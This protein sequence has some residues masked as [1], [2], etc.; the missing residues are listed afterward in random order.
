MVQPFLVCLFLF[1]RFVMISITLWCDIIVFVT[2]ISYI[3]DGLFVK[4][5]SNILCSVVGLFIICSIKRLSAM[6]R[7]SLVLFCCSLVVTVSVFEF[8]FI[9]GKLKSSIHNNFMVCTEAKLFKL[10]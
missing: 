7:R 9:D 3:I 1:S 4:I 5:R 6:L 8:Q 10:V 2:L